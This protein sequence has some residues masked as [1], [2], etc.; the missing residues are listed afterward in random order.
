MGGRQSTVVGA[1]EREEF[2]FAA[3]EDNALEYRNERA[4]IPIST[5]FSQFTN[6]DGLSFMTLRAREGMVRQAVDE[7]RSLLYAQHGVE[8]FE[9]RPSG[10]F[11]DGDSAEFMLLFNYIFLVVGAVSLFTGGIVIANILLASVVE[12]IRELGTQMAIGATPGSIFL[13]TLAEVLA[14]TGVGGVAGLAIGTG[15]TTVVSKFMSLPAVVTPGIAAIGL[16]TALGV[17]LIAGLYPA[18]RAARIAPVEALRA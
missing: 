13:Q 5:A 7:I 11:A 18:L 6:H 9:I 12:R 3:W 14:V 4:Y 15:L 1:L 10:S 17:G 2:Y 16:A 8:D